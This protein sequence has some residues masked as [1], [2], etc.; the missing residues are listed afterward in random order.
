MIS[1][2]NYKTYQHLNHKNNYVIQNVKKLEIKTPNNT[3]L[4]GYS[5]LTI[6]SINTE[7]TSTNKAKS[8]ERRSSLK[9]C[10]HNDFS[11]LGKNP[12]TK[13]NKNIAKNRNYK[14]RLNANKTS[15]NPNNSILKRNL[16]T[17]GNK[18]RKPMTKYNTSNNFY[19]IPN[20]KALLRNKINKKKNIIRNIYN[21]ISSIKN[22]EKDISCTNDFKLNNKE[23][24]DTSDLKK[25]K[26]NTYINNNISMFNLHFNNNT[27]KS[28]NDST[29]SSNMKNPS[30]ENKKKTIRIEDENDTEEENEVDKTNNLFNLIN[31]INYATKKKNKPEK[32][33]DFEF[34]FIN[35]QSIKNYNRSY[36]DQ[37]NYKSIKDYIKD[38]QLRNNIKANK[39]K[40][41]TNNIIKKNFYAE[42]RR[43]NSHNNRY[44]STG[45]RKINIPD[46]NKSKDRLN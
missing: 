19:K 34:E 23:N 40:I 45:K 32:K 10:S 6:N 35:N 39:N 43:L 25:K 11:I 7:R 12:I 28:N 17:K 26:N 3:S 21:D 4:I 37:K 44:H 29:F 30:I 14:L 20:Q 41:K 9:I 13:G 2:T 24:N 1:N 31:M 42:R 46:Y 15:E 8:T 22:L 38:I 36:Y 5:N 33:N 27:N 18:N 16:E